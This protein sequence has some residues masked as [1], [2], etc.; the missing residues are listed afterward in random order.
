MASRNFGILN[1]NRI[2]RIA[3]ECH[4]IIA[5]DKMATLILTANNVQGSHPITLLL[6]DSIR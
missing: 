3:T 2:G 5:Q 6:L 1:M 4:G